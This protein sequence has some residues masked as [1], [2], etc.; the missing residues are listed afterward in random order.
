MPIEPDPV[1]LNLEVQS[2]NDNDQGRG[3]GSFLKGSLMRSPGM[4]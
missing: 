3:A 4:T 1:A 2:G